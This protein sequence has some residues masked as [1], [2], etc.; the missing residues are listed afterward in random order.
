[1]KFK[2]ILA[3]IS[4]SS[5]VAAAPV[6]ENSRRALIPKPM[7]LLETMY[8]HSGI[9]KLA[10]KV[11]KTLNLCMYSPGKMRRKA[12][13]NLGRTETMLMATGIPLELFQKHN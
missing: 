1:M 7:D 6:G 2:A 13:A 10:M 8:P 4:L 9:P 3:A 11:E 12:T 5:M